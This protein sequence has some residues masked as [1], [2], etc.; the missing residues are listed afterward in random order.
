MPFRENTSVTACRAGPCGDS[1][2][3]NL[4]KSASPVPQLNALHTGSSDS[5][6]CPWNCNCINQDF[7]CTPIFGGIE[8]E[9]CSELKPDITALIMKFVAKMLL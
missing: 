8:T 2:A 7:R 9:V 3:S 5:S 6:V 4:Q 1:L